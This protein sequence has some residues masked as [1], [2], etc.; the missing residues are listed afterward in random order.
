VATREEAAAELGDSGGDRHRK[1]G[2]EAEPL[3]EPRRPARP[4]AAEGA[5]ELLGSMGGNR[6]PEHKPDQQQAACHDYAAAS[7]ARSFDDRSKP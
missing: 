5:E 2:S 7:G 4:L 6:Q 1:R 3:E